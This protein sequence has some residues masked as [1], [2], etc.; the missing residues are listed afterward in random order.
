MLLTA[1][2][3]LVGFLAGFESRAW[4]T[5]PS[6]AKDVDR[7]TVAEAHASCSDE[8]AMQANRVLASQVREYKARLE[9]QGA[10]AGSVHAT[11]EDNAFHSGEG[12]ALVELPCAS[13]NAGTEMHRVS[14][15]SMSY[16]SSGDGSDFEH[17]ARAAGV[18]PDAFPM[19]E[20]GYRAARKR[21]DKHVDDA[22][23]ADDAAK[24][25]WETYVKDGALESIETDTDLSPEERSEKISEARR[26]HC[27]DTKFSNAMNQTTGKREALLSTL[28]ATGSFQRLL[29]EE[30][31]T[32][33]GVDA[34]ARL[35]SLNAFCMNEH[36][37]EFDG[38]E[39]ADEPTDEPAAQDEEREE[40]RRIARSSELT[41]FE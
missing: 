8:G 29:R 13:W 24:E 18:S 9:T 23:L 14:S 4:V 28:P 22:C 30:L 33:I 39:T 41:L 5:R 6:L 36:S 15:G 17:R 20:E 12:V 38:E 37:A 25:G 7:T 27:V 1:A 10:S 2:G 26:V 21:F 32:R 35:V 3:L 34:S 16:R 31:E 11:R 19:L 40:P